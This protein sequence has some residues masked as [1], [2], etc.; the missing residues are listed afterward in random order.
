MPETISMPEADAEVPSSHESP[1]GSGR[2]ILLSL[3]L[4]TAVLVAIALLTHEPGTYDAVRDSFRPAMFIAVLAIVVVRVVVGGWRISYASRQHISLRGGIR[5]QLAWDLFSVVTPSVIGGGPIA[6]FFLARDQRIS[7]GEATSIFLYLMVLDQ[8]FFALTVP[9]VVIG[10]FFLPVLPEAIGTVGMTTVMLYFLIMLLWVGTL[11][12]ATLLK[13][14]LLQRFANRV[15]RTRLLRRFRYRVEHESELLSQRSSAIRGQGPRYFLVCSA[16]TL[17]GWLAKHLLVVLAI[18]CFQPTVDT[19]LVLLKSA[20]LMLGSLIMPTP[21]GSGGVETLFALLIGPAV[22]RTTL[23]PSLIVWRTLG[24]YV[25][26][27]AGAFLT[28]SHA[29]A[30]RSNAQRGAKPA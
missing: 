13:P 28:M 27:A 4:S 10:S 29:S 1:R 9:V 22:A 19:L 24:Y 17:A 21:G 8:L 7:T 26:L 6:A 30:R 2:S 15:A 3:L 23:V 5:G 20:A 11:A 16:L 12:Y 18:L 14:E 25:F